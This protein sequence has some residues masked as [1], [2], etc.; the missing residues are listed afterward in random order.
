MNHID[1]IEALA[2]LPPSA[3]TLAAEDATLIEKMSRAVVRDE[4]ASSGALLK[5][6]QS[7]L[8]A[9]EREAA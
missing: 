3:P 5:L 6:V 7:E 2:G 8:R 9:E 1:V 4:C